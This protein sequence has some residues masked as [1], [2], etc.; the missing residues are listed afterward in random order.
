[1]PKNRAEF[2]VPTKPERLLAALIAILRHRLATAR[3]AHLDG[4]TPPRDDE[5][6]SVAHDDR[7]QNEAKETLVGLVW[8]RSSRRVQ[9]SWRERTRYALRLD[10]ARAVPIRAR[11]VVLRTL[12]PK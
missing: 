12:F 11:I 10:D 9:L 1:M 8:Q 5:I 3:F 6:P 4:A 7:R 2:A